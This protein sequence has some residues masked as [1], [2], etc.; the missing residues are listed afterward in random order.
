MNGSVC[1]CVF[2]CLCV[3]VCVCVSKWLLPGTDHY[4]LH[5]GLTGHTDS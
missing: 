3:C 1:V 5:N 4:N 2:V